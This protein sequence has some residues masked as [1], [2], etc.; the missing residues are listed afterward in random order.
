MSSDSEEGTISES[1]EDSSDQVDSGEE[2][3]VVSHFE[4]Y[5]DEPLASEDGDNE[6]EEDEIDADGLTPA[7][8]EAR[9]ERQIA[10]LEWLVKLSKHHNRATVR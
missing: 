6:D 5:E 4:P 2:I 9:F 7:V 8:L 3:E 1:S 10:I